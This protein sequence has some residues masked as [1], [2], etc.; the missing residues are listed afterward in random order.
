M[1][2]EGLLLDLGDRWSNPSHDAR[3]G[4]GAKGYFHYCETLVGSFCRLGSTLKDH[5]VIS[6]L[7]TKGS[8]LVAT[9]RFQSLNSDEITTLWV[10]FCHLYRE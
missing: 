7:H 8:V 3:G 9:W 2:K 5:V 10:K 4:F 1:G 6:W